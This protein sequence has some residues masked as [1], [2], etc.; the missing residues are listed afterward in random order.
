M[1]LYGDGESME[2]IS[3]RSFIQRGSVG[4]AAVT[5]V[6]VVPLVNSAGKKP[7]SVNNRAAGTVE[8]PLVAHISDTKTGE[9]HLMFGDKEVVYHST[10]L[11]N[12]LLNAAKLPA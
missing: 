4:L 2:N 6:A 10:E 7:Q 5:A 9:I 11:V 8:G 3:R 12:Q 1:V